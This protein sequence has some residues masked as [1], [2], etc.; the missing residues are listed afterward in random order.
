M[1][2]IGKLEELHALSLYVLTSTLNFNITA[3]HK[4]LDR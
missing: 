2:V 1:H 3:L 4:G